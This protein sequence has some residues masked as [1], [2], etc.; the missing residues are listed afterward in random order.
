VLCVVK[1]MNII[2]EAKDPRDGASTLVV[3]TSRSEALEALN[4]F[5]REGLDG[6]QS[7]GTHTREGNTWMLALRKL[8]RVVR[9]GSACV[10]QAH[11]ARRVAGLAARSARS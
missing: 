5:R 7:A 10:P 8:F 11:S 4:D 3:C 9:N 1:V 6:R 2:V